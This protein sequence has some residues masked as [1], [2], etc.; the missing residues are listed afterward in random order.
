MTREP[1]PVLEVRGLTVAFPGHVALDAVD[2]RMFPGEVH[3]LLGE[4][5]AGKSTLIKAI[6]G[7]HVPDGGSI[8][9]DG[10]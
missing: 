9:F 7:A 5:G 10:R 2:F 4:N 6:T 8:S 3:A 1:A